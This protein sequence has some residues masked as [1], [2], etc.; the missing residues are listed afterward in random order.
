MMISGLRRFDSNNG[1]GLSESL[2]QPPGHA[3][4]HKY[5]RDT[6]EE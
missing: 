4:I 3:V 6:C 1:Q 5:V 2:S